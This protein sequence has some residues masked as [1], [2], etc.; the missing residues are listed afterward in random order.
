MSSRSETRSNLRQP[1]AIPLHFEEEDPKSEINEV[2][3]RLIR[4]KEVLA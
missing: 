3:S 2:K 4:A 1:E